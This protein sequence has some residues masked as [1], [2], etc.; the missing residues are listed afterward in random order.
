[1]CDLGGGGGAMEVIPLFHHVPSLFIT[2]PCFKNI[3]F[4]GRTKKGLAHYNMFRA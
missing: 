2:W 3:N 1:M 4:S